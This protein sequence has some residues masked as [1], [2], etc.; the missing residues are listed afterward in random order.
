[1]PKKYNTYNKELKLRAIDMYIN[2]GMST[3][4]VARALNIK[5]KTQVQRW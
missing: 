1:M 5:N 2:E 3:L 4:S